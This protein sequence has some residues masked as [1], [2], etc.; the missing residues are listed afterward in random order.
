MFQFLNSLM[1]ADSLISVKISHFAVEKSN[2]LQDNV[3]GGG[4]GGGL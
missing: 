4:G 1:Q 3:G 2:L